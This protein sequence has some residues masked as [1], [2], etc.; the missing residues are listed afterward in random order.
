MA[1]ARDALDAGAIEARRPVER[2]LDLL[3]QHAVTVAARRRL[4]C[5]TSCCAEVRTTHAYR[6][7]TDA[8]WRWVLDFI[9]RGG[10][11]LR[12]YPEYSKVVVR[13]GRYV[14]REPRWSRCGTGCRSAPS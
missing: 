6:D 9:T 10:D 14:V 13:D 2:P 3:A 8:E 11:A 5:R 12:A 4:P 7:L 1:A